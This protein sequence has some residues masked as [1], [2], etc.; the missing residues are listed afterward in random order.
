MLIIFLE[1]H[2]SVEAQLKL[3]F[4]N[5]ELVLKLVD[6]IIENVPTVSFFLLSILLSQ[7]IT[8][9]SNFA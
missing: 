7:S 8:N 6:E 1:K 2:K 5:E 9:Y 4:A 3:L